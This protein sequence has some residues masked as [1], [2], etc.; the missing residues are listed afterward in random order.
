MLL[1]SALAAFD[2]A[3]HGRACGPGRVGL[4]WF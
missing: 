2:S 3:V 1:M 4:W